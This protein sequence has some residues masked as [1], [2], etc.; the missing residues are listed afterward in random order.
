[1]ISH[2][3]KKHQQEPRNISSEGRQIPGPLRDPPPFAAPLKTNT[4]LRGEG[5]RSLPGPLRAF[6]DLSRAL[7]GRC[8]RDA[9]LLKRGVEFRS[10]KGPKVPNPLDPWAGFRPSSS[11]PRAAMEGFKSLRFQAA[12]GLDLES[13]SI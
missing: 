3:G 7:R 10:F 4:P 13:L 1:M 12:S 8:V 2:D 11:A 6:P 9:E 5:L